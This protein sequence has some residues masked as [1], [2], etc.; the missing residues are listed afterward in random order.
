L[1]LRV[2]ETRHLK[3]AY[4]VAQARLVIRGVDTWETTIGIKIK[5]DGQGHIASIRAEYEDLKRAVEEIGRLGLKTPFSQLRQLVETTAREKYEQG[6]DVV[7]EL[8]N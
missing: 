7:V 1:G 5:R 2:F 3:F 4:E 8:V 6:V